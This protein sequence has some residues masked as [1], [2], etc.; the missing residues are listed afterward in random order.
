[1]DTNIQTTHNTR[2]IL[3][4]CLPTN[5][6]LKIEFYSFL[7]PISVIIFLT[8]S[9]EVKNLNFSWVQLISSFNLDTSSYKEKQDNS[10]I[11]NKHPLQNE[12]IG[13]RVSYFYE[14]VFF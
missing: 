1:M 6:Y 13:K 9:Q 3:N 14:A 7:N 4:S 2:P 11:G 10:Q 12:R 8:P 5:F